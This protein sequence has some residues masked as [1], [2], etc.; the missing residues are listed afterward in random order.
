MPTIQLSLPTLMEPTAQRMPP[1]NHFSVPKWDES[2]LRELTQYFKELEYLFRDCGIIDHTQMKEYTARYITY[3]TAETWIGLPKFAAT[4]ILDG[5]QAATAISY[6]NW[7]EAVICLYPGAEESTRYT[8]T[9]HPKDP[10]DVKDVYEAGN[11]HLKG[12]DMSLGILRAK[13]I[14]PVPT[15][16]Q[17][18]NNTVITNSYIKKE[19]MEAAISATVASAMTHI[20][21]MNNTQLRWVRRGTDG[22]VVLSTGANIPNYPELK[23]YQER[24]DE[25]HRCNPGNVATSTLS[26]NANPNTDQHVQQQLIYKVLHLDSVGDKGGLSKE[27]HIAA[28]EMGLNALKNQVFNGVEVSRP[29][30]PLKGYKPMAT[31]ANDPAPPAPEA[32]SAPTSTASTD[33]TLPIANVPDPLP[34]LHPYSGLN[35]HYQSLVQQEFGALDK[36]TDGAYQPTALSG[37]ANHGGSVHW[38]NTL[39]GDH[40]VHRRRAPV[41]C[42]A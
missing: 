39:C 42:E 18:T 15:Q 29:K 41:G 28:L 26:G 12:T 21:T 8:P 6:K 22:K 4:T 2:K 37:S 17:A 34:P 10:Y 13:G 24:V 20:E 30:Q 35:N 3:N 9:H 27:S 38:A 7:K 1:C 23:S 36:R 14:L 19:D 40:H 25:W 11:W 33:N 5:D 16:P 32:P 31:V